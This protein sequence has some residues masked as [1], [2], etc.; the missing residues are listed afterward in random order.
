[1]NGRQL[2]STVFAQIRRNYGR[3]R[4]VIHRRPLRG[5]VI[6]PLT[7]QIQS[8]R[9][10]SYS[11]GIRV[12][13]VAHGRL[14]FAFRLLV[15]CGADVTWTGTAAIATTATTRLRNAQA[16]QLSSVRRQM[17]CQRVVKSPAKIQFSYSL[18][19]TR[20][21]RKIWRCGRRSA[22]RYGKCDR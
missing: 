21:W 3:T 22:S 20:W 18:R 1:M 14:I 17:C 8:A 9:Y 10:L 5:P 6:K 16:G 15:D 12:D 11:T 2:V 13:I 7:R 19:E 4:F